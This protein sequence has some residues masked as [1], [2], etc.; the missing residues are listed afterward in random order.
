MV[1]ETKDGTKMIVPNVSTILG[2]QANLNERLNKLEGQGM[3]ET[4]QEYLDFLASQQNQPMGQAPIT[5]P[6]LDLVGTVPGQ[7]IQSPAINQAPRMQKIVPSPMPAPAKIPSIPV[8]ANKIKSVP[9]QAPAK[10]PSAPVK[11]NKIN[12][13]EQKLNKI[14]SMVEDQKRMQ[15]L[16]FL[17][18]RYNDTT[19]AFTKKYV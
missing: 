4:S 19:N 3:N 13:T 10:I 2:A 9:G 8:P 12:S 15:Y 11:A 5:F 6:P 14:Q 7:G 16:D 18:K 1:G 17:M